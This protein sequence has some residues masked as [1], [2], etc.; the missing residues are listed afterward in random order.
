MAKET[1]SLPLI[2]T[3]LHRPPVTEDLVPRPQL[4]ERLEK[5]RQRPLALVSAAAGYGK[6]TLV[7]WWLDR[8][9]SPFAWVSLDENDN[10]LNQFLNYFVAAVQSIFPSACSDT[11]ALANAPTMP[12]IPVLASSLANELDSIEQGF[13]LVLDDIHRI[14]EKSVYDLLN[15]LLDHPPRP[16][17][18]VLVG[19]RDPLLPIAK[20][21]G[22]NRMTE[23][24]T[25][26]LRFSAMETAAYLQRALGEQINESAAAGLA[27][28][29]EG[30]VA[31]LR[32]AILAMRG[33]DNALSKLL[34]LKGT[35]AYLLDYLITEVLDSQIPAIRRY[36]LSTSIL[37]RFCVPLCDV[38][39]APDLEPGEGE[40]DGQ[41]FI[42]LAQQSNLFMIPLDTENRWVRYH[43]LFQNLLQ[44]Q[45][46]R[47][48]SPKE[49]AT[50]HSR[51]SE[52]FESQG[53][54]TESIEH[55]LEAGDAKSAAKII[56]RHR[57]EEF[58]ADRW[59]VV[60]RWLAM[61][62]AEI[63]RERPKLL[64]AEAWIGTMK[65]QLHRV[66]MLLDQ[67]ESLP[68]SQTEDL[69][70]SGEIGFF[71]GYITYFEGQA[72]SS[73]K[74]LEDSASQLAITKSPFLGDAELFLGLARSMVG[75]K[76]RAVRGL[77]ARI[78]EV[79]PSE[80][81]LLSRLIASLAF[82][83]LLWGDLHLARGEA[84]NLQRVSTKHKLGLA[85]AWSYY[86][87]ACTHLHVGE[88]EPASLHFA[89]AVEQR[90]VLEP[91]AAL[92]ALAGLVLTQQFMGLG[93]EA[94][95]SCHRLQE[96]AQ[97]LHERNYLSLAQSC[98]AR[99]S[100]LQG[101]VNS[102]VEW[103]RS[104]DESPVL[105]ELFMWL[106]APS[107][108]QARVLIAAGSEQSLLNATKLLQSIRD[109]CEACRLTCQIIEVAVL[110]SLA[111][112]QLAR[113][114]EAFHAL[115]EVV[116]LAGP[117]GWIRPFVE[118]GPPMAD[119]LKRLQKQ[120]EAVD[121]IERLLAAFTNFQFTSDDLRFESE[122][123]TAIRNQKSKIQNSLV[124][125][126]TNRE[127]EILELLAQR[128][129]NKEIADKLFVSIETVKTHLNNIYQKLQVSNRREA[130][131][132]ARR[133][134]ILTRG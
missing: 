107:I 22:S 60:V 7:S 69:T 42:T 68:R 38:L 91:R 23:I 29:T 79:D 115:E 53:L 134:G 58:I 124:E 102:A 31:G 117:R 4:L 39:C 32:L 123:L 116:S 9:E 57:N 30:W 129:Q 41:G 19:R 24:R 118:A 66:P 17:H 127:L 70:L 113:A 33:Q 21:R 98:Q 126:L 3:K 50:L 122:A 100:L 35:T 15:M 111:L 93:D 88:L 40:I 71:R 128:L 95:E 105:A 103:G 47:T 1:T 121:Y 46:K 82:I 49:I 13:I 131:N 97:E 106:E 87:L 104:V 61:L 132:Q 130:V 56:E 119:L 16:M 133:L 2:S 109:L 90:Y 96:F 55:A 25:L 85:E 28:R 78:G 65:H 73:L 120:S 84:Q 83:H 26:D 67:A 18:L 44:S 8:C 99:L 59:H 86:F 27:E 5:N 10:D 43:H 52:W 92:D 51:A 77:E 108:T 89:Q 74:Y 48:C 62:P 72:E 54:I 125:P 63:K 76:D 14:H 94:A 110:Q 45:L 20:L 81:Y 12:P 11:L 101:D 36:L 34:E 6:S 112:D 114:D 37:D 75:E 80:N 64:L